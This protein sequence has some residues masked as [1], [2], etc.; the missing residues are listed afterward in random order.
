VLGPVLATAAASFDALAM[1]KPQFELGRGRVGKGGVVGRPEDRREA[2]ILVGEAV[3]RLG[4]SVL[5]FHSSGLAGPKGNRETFVH[6]AEAGRPD[7]AAGAARPPV[8]KLAL[9]VEPS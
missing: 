4:V 8:E 1:I 5:G 7:G 3:R 9:A 6:L 2:L